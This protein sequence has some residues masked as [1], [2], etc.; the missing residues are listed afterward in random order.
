MIDR[1]PLTGALNRNAF[2]TRLAEAIHEAGKTGSGFALL[3][4]DIDNMKR[5]NNHNGHLVGDQ[6]L[7]RFVELVEPML[8]NQDSLF[9]VG[10]DEFA[11]ILPKFC[12]EESLHLSQ[13]I[14]DIAREKLAP[15]QPVH[16]GDKHCMGP[17]K[18]SASI[19][20]GLFEQN[21]SAESLSEMVEKK[22]YDAKCAGRDR[23]SMYTSHG[24]KLRFLEE[25]KA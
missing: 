1:D 16:C 10:G 22:M 24:H 17:A 15:P 25:L 20:I 21:M 11:I 8:G 18:I 12:R 7:K 2:N 14:C 13:Q 6:L 19:G 23:V 5:F 3:Y 4:V 9:R